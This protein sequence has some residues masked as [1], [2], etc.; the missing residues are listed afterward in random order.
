MCFVLG[1]KLLDYAMEI[2]HWLSSKTLQ[3]TSGF[4]RCISKINNVSFIGAIKGITFLI[5]WFDAIY[6]A[7][8]VLKEIYV[9]KFLHNNSGH[10]AYIITYHVCNM[11]CSALSESSRPYPPAKLEST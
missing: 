11:T 10:T 1:G 9:C 8:I 2:Q 5:S 6:Y 4:G 7:S 3:K